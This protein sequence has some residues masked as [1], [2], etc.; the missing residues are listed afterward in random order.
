VEVARILGRPDILTYYSINAFNWRR[1]DTAGP[2]ALGNISRLNNFL[3]GQDEEWFS[4]VHIAIEALAGEGLTAAVA[5]QRTVAH[6]AE[7]PSDQELSDWYGCLATDLEIV[8]DT[9][10]GMVATLQRMKE[11]CDPYIYYMRVRVFM[12]GW[13]ADELPDGMVYSSVPAHNGED[14]EGPWRRERFYGETGAQS[15]VV[16]ALD[17]ALGLT[18]SDDP[19]LPY[20]EAMRDYMPPKHSDFISRLE[21]GPSVRAVVLHAAQRQVGQPVNEGAKKLVQAY[22]RSVN[23]LTQ[24]RSVHFEL[25]F[26]F[27]RKWDERKD[28][29]IKGTGG[30]PFMPYLKKHR[31]ATRELLVEWSAGE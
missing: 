10:D 1:L 31:Q 19:L 17:H 18:M 23:S 16:P 22:N 13:T 4:T 11:R 12:K 2:I 15:S 7:G 27:V 30:T 29:E 8:A 25:A 21:H 28:E 14:H 26:S 9:V 24:F 20:L 5:A 3:G 6:G